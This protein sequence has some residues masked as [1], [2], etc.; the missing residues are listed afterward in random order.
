ML[1]AKTKT[2]LFTT[3]PSM[4]APLSAFSREARRSVC[5]TVVL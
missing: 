2:T 3:V 1:S 4:L 5:P